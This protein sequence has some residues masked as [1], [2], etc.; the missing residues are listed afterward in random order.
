VKVR[1]TAAVDL[2]KITVVQSGRTSTHRADLV[3][4]WTIFYTPKAA[5]A[6]AV[7]MQYADLTQMQYADT[8]SMEYAT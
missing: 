6:A 7:V 3:P 2:H 1:R 5:A 4:A 8:T